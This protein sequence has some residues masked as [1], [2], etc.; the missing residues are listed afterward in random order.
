MNQFLIFGIALVILVFIAS[1]AFLLF[2]WSAKKTLVRG[3]TTWSAKNIPIRRKGFN[4]SSKRAEK[5]IP[6]SMLQS[7]SDQTR[8]YLTSDEE[9]NEKS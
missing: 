2:A 3:E 5:A 7:I 1:L 9:L 8:E 6:S 4:S